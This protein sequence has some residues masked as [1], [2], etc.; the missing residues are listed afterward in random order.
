ML[1]TVIQVSKNASVS[2]NNEIVGQIDKGFTILVGICNEDTEE[3]VKKMADKI[4]NLRI[5]PDENG[6]TNLS[7]K[8]VGGSILSISQFTLYADCKKGN[9]PS[10]T[11]A[12]KRE[13]ATALYDYFNEYLRSLN[14]KVETGVFGAD[15]EVSLTNVGPFTIVLDS[16]EVL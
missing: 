10:F 2:I 11:L 9:R 15:M 12:G 13:L 8:D 16:K 3:I 14:Y 7:L 6:K 1:K 4:V 5:F